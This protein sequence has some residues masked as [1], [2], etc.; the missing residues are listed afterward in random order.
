MSKQK[1]EPDQV[2]LT[3][4]LHDLPTAQHR[5]GLAGLIL[6]ID[7]MGPSANRRNP[8]LVPIIDEAGLT[9]TRVTITFTRES[10]QGI[11][12]DLYAAKPVDQKFPKPKTKKGNQIPWDTIEEATD[13]KGN[14][15]KLYVYKSG[16]VVPLSPCLRYFSSDHASAWIELWHRMVWEVL[17]NEQARNPFKQVAGTGSCAIGSQ[18]WEQIVESVRGI[19]IATAKRK[20]SGALLLAGQSD[21]AEVVPM[22]GA[23]EH[24]LLLHFWQVTVFVFAPYIYNK[25]E[26]KLKRKGYVLAIPDVANLKQF[27]SDFRQMMAARSE[28]T[29]G[30]TPT[31]ARLDLPEQAGLEVYRYLEQD[32]RAE[33]ESSAPKP[34]RPKRPN[35]TAT[36]LA[37]RA[38]S[39]RDL[40]AAQAS[41][42]LDS[43]VRAVET[44]H[45]L[46][47]GN[48]VKL[49]S[50]ARLVGRPGLAADYDQVRKNYRNRFFRAAL[51]RG[52]IRDESWHL[53]MA[54]LFARYPW[55]YFLQT[56][57]SPRYLPRF[58]RDA[59]DLLR[60]FEKA[61]HAMPT[62]DMSD[63]DKIRHLSVL[64][65]RL[66]NRYIDGRAASKLGLKLD[67]IPRKNVDGKSRLA[68]PDP[69]R[70]REAQ[71]RVCSDA[72]LAMRSK[73][74]QDFVE[75]F[76]GSVCSVAQYLAQDDYQFLTAILLTNPDRSN[77]VGLKRLCWED[78]KT[79]AMFAV[80]AQAFNVRD[81]TSSPQ[82]SA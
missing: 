40:A 71:Q 48:I 3:F 52:L 63:E 45:M 75:F 16:T 54:G 55:S 58:G 47:Q 70:F 4:D 10:M 28:S 1:A 33:A 49:L 19:P 20:L 39:L 15:Q 69:D 29:S 5:A 57:D 13:S 32:T 78:V 65:R 25:K 23:I 18:S 24:N 27:R 67:K 73:H 62:S 30:R 35:P 59:R 66:M 8:K 38:G 72:Y 36:D 80:S 56:E 22:A 11:F 50:F 61:I 68:P 79:I 43:S 74:D 44:Y 77:P 2:S 42:G 64:L 31:L 81:R 12:D 9:P 7:S 26:E 41:V 37:E 82:G 17:R 46:K 21:N 14:K 34:R 60:S 76:A 51:M 53:G 6:Q